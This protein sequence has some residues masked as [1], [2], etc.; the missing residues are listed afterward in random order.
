MKRSSTKFLGLGLASLAAACAFF[1]LGVGGS[2]AMP[3]SHNPNPTTAEC[4][5]GQPYNEA[6]ETI[7]T[8]TF[9][10]TTK[11]EGSKFEL[12]HLGCNDS[13]NRVN[14]R[15]KHGGKVIAKGTSAPEGNY[16]PVIHAGLTAWG[17]EQLRQH[18][19][20]TGYAHVCVHPPGPQNFC[21][22]AELTI[23]R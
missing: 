15:V 7:V 23:K 10:K 12:V 17:K 22:G 6:C 3:I 20:L 21:K 11:V 4:Q 8:F 14:F 16:L 18:G 2:A 9:P 19:K 1:V 5:P 13:C